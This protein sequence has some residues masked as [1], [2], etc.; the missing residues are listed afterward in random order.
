MSNDITYY[1][2]EEQVSGEW[3]DDFVS[4]VGQRIEIRLRKYPVIK[5]TPRG[6]WII[7]NYGDRKFILNDSRKRF[8]CETKEKAMESFIARKTRQASILRAQLR[9][10]E[11]ALSIAVLECDVILGRL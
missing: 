1:R 8:A 3:D 4:L 9:S 2:Y 10:V 6:V 11:K 7:H 5:H